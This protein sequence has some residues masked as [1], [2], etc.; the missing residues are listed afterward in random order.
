MPGRNL[1]YRSSRR[2]PRFEVR[3]SR[4]LVATAGH[5]CSGLWS[6]IVVAGL[7]VVIGAIFLGNTKDAN[8]GAE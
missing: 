4:L 1:S 7:A 5:L 6:P 8:L 2:K 3:P